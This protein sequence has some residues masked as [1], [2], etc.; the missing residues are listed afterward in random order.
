MSLLSE[1]DITGQTKGYWWEKRLFTHPQTKNQVGFKSLP[2]EE[3]KRLNDMVRKN[4]PE[5][6]K[7]E[8]SK[9]PQP[10]EKVEPQVPQPKEK[11]EPQVKPKEVEPQVKPQVKPKEVEPQVKP[12]PKKKV[13]PQPKEKPVKNMS[14]VKKEAPPAGKEEKP[15]LDKGILNSIMER[16]SPAK[17]QNLQ[18]L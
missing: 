5:K 7:P 13:K 18:N 14:P 1:R 11:V 8:P 17:K 10:K 12:Q 16:L 2:L 3:Q 4:T 6:F 9:P 15:K